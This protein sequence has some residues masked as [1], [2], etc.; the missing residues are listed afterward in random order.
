MPQKI[1]LPALLLI[2]LSSLFWLMACTTPTDL[3][4]VAVVSPTETPTATPSATMTSPPPSPTPTATASPSL[5][6][7][8]TLTPEPVATSE[9]ASIERVVIIS[10][11]GLRPDALTEA[12]TPV[13]DSLRA[14][15]AY[16]PAAQA[17]LP[18][19]TLV[20]HA[21]M[22]GGMSPAGHG[23]S[24]NVSNP[25][26]GYI[27]GPTVFSV[28]KAAGLTTA[29]VSG[30]PKLQHVAIPDTVDHYI[31]AGFLDTQ[32]VQETLAL[33]QRAQP[34]LLVLHL[35]DVDSAGHAMG[36]MTETQLWTV[37]QTDALVGQIVAALQMQGLW[38][39]T[40][41]ILTSDHGGE[42]KAHGP[43]TPANV[44]IPWLAVGPG[45]P[46]NLTLTEELV[47]YDTAATVLHA[48]DLPIPENW[49][50]RPVLEIFPQ[51]P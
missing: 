18:S 36:W 17:V 29:L 11:D 19:V 15:G 32:V 25:D 24:W 22:L 28:L 1:T 50:G 41:L 45:V 39:S 5:T 33:L 37:S 35:P 16:H 13:F 20:N 48:F 43:D 49:D 21:S 8:P 40:L 4:A 30:K 38:K 12:D 3:P 2:L 6:P 26:L 31:Y 23:I 47:I 51:L 14:W 27:N 7:T 42:G 10:V 9:P 34:H 46:P 44:L